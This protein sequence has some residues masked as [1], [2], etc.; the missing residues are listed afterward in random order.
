MPIL[1]LLNLQDADF[2][3]EW[4]RTNTGSHRNEFGK[5]PAEGQQEG[6]KYVNCWIQ[7]V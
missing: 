2:A 1:T 4:V 7:F 3:V 5:P 6:V